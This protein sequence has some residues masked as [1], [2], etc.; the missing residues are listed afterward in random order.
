MLKIIEIFKIEGIRKKIF[1]YKY[2]ILFKTIND[3]RYKIILKHEK[4]IKISKINSKY[5]ADYEIHKAS[6]NN[7][8]ET[9]I[10]LGLYYLIK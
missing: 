1:K 3:L 5:N 6:L 7:W 8:R 10:V 2:D 9:A 4:L